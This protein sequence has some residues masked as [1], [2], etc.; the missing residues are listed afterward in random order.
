VGRF[1]GIA[2]RTDV[3]PDVMGLT[4]EGKVDMVEIVSRWQTKKQLHRKL[5]A[6]MSRLPAEM[7]GEYIAIDPQDASK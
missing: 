2:Y 3:K 5:K 7:Q 4:W 6:A 1:L